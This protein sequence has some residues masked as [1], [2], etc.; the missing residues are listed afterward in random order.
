MNCISSIR[1]LITL[2][3]V[4]GDVLNVLV[5]VL[6]YINGTFPPIWRHAVLNHIV[7]FSVTH[8]IFR[9]EISLEHMTFQWQDKNVKRTLGVL[10]RQS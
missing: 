1:R 8:N 6:D 7:V 9:N 10:G 5:L 2:K 4:R 3:W